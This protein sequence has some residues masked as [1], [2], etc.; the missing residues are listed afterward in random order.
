MIDVKEVIREAKQYREASGDHK[1]WATE[2][3]MLALIAAGARLIHW[4]FEQC[5]G[6]YVTEVIYEKP[7]FTNTSR[8]PLIL[9]NPIDH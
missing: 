9:T 7:Y 6:T 5:D 3:E 8:N 2:E 4:N 1:S